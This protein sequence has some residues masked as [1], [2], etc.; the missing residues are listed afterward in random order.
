MKSGATESSFY[1]LN[2]HYKFPEEV[3]VKRTAHELINSNKKYKIIWA[4]D[5]CDQGVHYDLPRHINNIDLIVCVSNW[6]REQYIKYNRAPS[7]KLV[8]IPNGVDAMFRP[9]KNPKSKTCIFFSAPHKG[10]APL[11]PIWKEVIKQ[12]PDAKLKVFSSMCLYGEH[13]GN[14]E[15]EQVQSLN[16]LEK[17]PFVSTYREL[18][19][20]PGVEYSPCISRDELLPHIQDAAFFVHPNIWEETFCVS[21]AESMCCGCFPI[22]SN[23]GALMETSNGMGKYVKMIGKTTP[24]GWIPEDQ[25][26]YNFAQELIRCFYYFDVTREQFEFAS[27]AISNF[28]IEEYDWKKIS[29]QWKN[30]IIHITN[31]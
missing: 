2:Q 17:S 29:Q 26:Y 31:K 16:G 9:S 6:E 10:V 27:S 4:H 12:H 13:Y 11:V 28:A 20:L 22:T 19:N 23:I 14:C 30:L 15:N 25:F 1:Y 21:L 5:N 8:V 24:S 18:K 7:S 3:D